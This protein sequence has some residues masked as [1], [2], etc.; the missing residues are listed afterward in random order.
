VQAFTAVPLERTKFD[1]KVQDVFALAKKEAYASGAF[2]GA[3]GWSGNVTVLALLGYG[4]RAP[5]AGRDVLWGAD[6]A[7][8]G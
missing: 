2:F 3:T 8:R 5:R 6:G 7:C 4:A 1:A